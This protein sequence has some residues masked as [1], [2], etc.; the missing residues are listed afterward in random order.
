MIVNN[1]KPSHRPQR[2]ADLIRES[3]ASFI[4]AGGPKDPRIGFITITQ[5][6]MTADLQIARVY[7][8]SYGSEAE[9]RETTTGLKESAGRIRSHLAKTLS[10]RAVPRLEFFIDEGLEQSYRIQELLGN[11]TQDSNH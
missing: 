5:V 10:M 6:K 2:V 1:A 4:V 11:I 8:S 7:Y 9:R 3:V